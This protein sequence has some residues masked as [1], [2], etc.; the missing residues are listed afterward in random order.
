VSATSINRAAN[1]VQLRARVDAVTHKEV[2]YDAELAA[3]VFGQSLLT[4]YGQMSSLYWAVAVVTEADYEAAMLSGNGS[5][6][7]DENVITDD[8]IVSAVKSHW[9]PDPVPP[10]L[11]GTQATSLPSTPPEPSSS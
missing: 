2:I 8:A 10:A 4:G 3:T 11:P 5:P 7:Y 9:P 6:G 1:D